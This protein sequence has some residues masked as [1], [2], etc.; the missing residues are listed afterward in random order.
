MRLWI[1]LPCTVVAMLLA[2]VGALYY[3]THTS[4]TPVSING[5]VAMTLG[6]VLTFALGA[7]LMFLVFLSARRGR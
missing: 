6:I 7:G 1:Y 4:E 3:V 2:I 5:L